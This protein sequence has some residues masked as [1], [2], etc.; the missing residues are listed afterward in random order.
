MC[1]LILLIISIEFLNFF[2]NSWKISDRL[3]NNS[4]S[5]IHFHLLFFQFLIWLALDVGQHACPSPWC[6]K[7]GSCWW[8]TCNV[9][10]LLLKVIFV[11]QCVF[12]LT[13]S[14]LHINWKVGIHNYNKCLPIMFLYH[15]PTKFPIPLLK[16]GSKKCKC[17][18]VPKSRC[19]I[20]FLSLDLISF[21]SL[22]FMSFIHIGNSII[23]IEEHV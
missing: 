3:S 20:S 11:F 12:T 1:E 14:A 19:G 6:I 4:R 2:H 15:L 13:P 7:I 9:G 18:I 10:I 21:L 8:S 17:Y 16:F 22:N 5:N 23:C